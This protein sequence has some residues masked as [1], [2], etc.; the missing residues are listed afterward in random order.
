MNFFSKIKVLFSGLSQDRAKLY[1]VIIGICVII[2]CIAVYF[3]FFHSSDKEKIWKPGEIAKEE[4]E[5]EYDKLR[6]EFSNE[7]NNSVRRLGQDTVNYKKKDESKDIVH[8]MYNIDLASHNNYDVEV[9]IPYI[10]IKGD[11]ADE[12]NKDI[13]NIFGAKVNSVV[14]SKR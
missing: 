11:I 7:F 1:G 9:H 3:Q 13:N 5:R 14:Q 6:D 2:I 10:N 8:T 12:I 4:E